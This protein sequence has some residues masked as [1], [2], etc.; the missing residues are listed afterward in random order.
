MKNK[1]FVRLAVVFV[2]IGGL[3]SAFYSYDKKVFA[4]ETREQTM[5]RLIEKFYAG[6]GTTL[7]ILCDAW[8][9]NM[10]Y[11]VMNGAGTGVSVVHQPENCKKPVQ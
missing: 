1:I 5:I 3:L 10:I 4:A 9:Q 7:T 11:I 2:L 8:R 6:D